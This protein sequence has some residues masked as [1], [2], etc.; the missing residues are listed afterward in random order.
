MLAELLLDD[1]PNLRLDAVRVEG[2]VTTLEIHSTATEAACP[3][4]GEPS[5]QVHS[6]YTRHPHDL[7][8]ASRF[9]GSYKCAVSAV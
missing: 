8:I 2:D 6:R 5:D 4:C 1:W 7:P 9:S 3:M